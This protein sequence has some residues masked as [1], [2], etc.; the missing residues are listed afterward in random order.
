MALVPPIA[1]RRQDQLT[2]IDALS[3]DNGFAVAIQHLAAHRGARISERECT[4]RQPFGANGAKHPLDERTW[5]AAQGRELQSG[6]LHHQRPLKALPRLGP[7]RAEDLLEIERL[8][9]R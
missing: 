6:V 3:D 2:T 8:N 4:A 5:E 9:L 1:A 7:F